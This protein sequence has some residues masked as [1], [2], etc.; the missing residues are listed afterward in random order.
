LRREA[1]SLGGF[2]AGG[3]FIT[4]RAVSDWRMHIGV[5][6]AG[7]TD[8]VREL[9]HWQNFHQTTRIKPSQSAISEEGEGTFDSPSALSL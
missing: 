7:I 1:A 3:R 6:A 4:T 2:A 5:L 9:L 8:A